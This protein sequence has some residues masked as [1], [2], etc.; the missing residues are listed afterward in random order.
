METFVAIFVQATDVISECA[1]LLLQHYPAQ[2][3]VHY[4]Y[5]SAAMFEHWQHLAMSAA[6]TGGRSSKET[7]IRHN[8]IFPN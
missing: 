7:K 8:V 5:A 1:P 2:D 3:D 4:K 6:Q